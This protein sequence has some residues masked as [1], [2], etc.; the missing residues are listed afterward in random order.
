VSSADRYLDDA[1]LRTITN[2]Q[3]RPRIDSV[4]KIMLGVV[5]RQREVP[6]FE[7]GLRFPMCHLI[8]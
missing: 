4:A 6:E 1:K 8:V 5:T 3:L 2:T 7:T